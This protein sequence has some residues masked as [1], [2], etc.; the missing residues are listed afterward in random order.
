MT[1]SPATPRPDL[2][3]RYACDD[4][5]ASETDCAPGKAAWSSWLTGLTLTSN[6]ES[7]LEHQG[8]GPGGA[9]WNPQAALVAFVVS[10]EAGRAQLQ[11]KGKPWLTPVARFDD[12]DVFVVPFGTWSAAARRARAGDLADTAM[13]DGVSVVELRARSTG[14][15]RGTF[16]FSRG[17]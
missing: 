5:Y 2:V 6:S 9:E 17:E 15:T 8:G 13:I 3:L 7:L 4:K 11:V 14:E 16:A 12:Y 10:A 1:T